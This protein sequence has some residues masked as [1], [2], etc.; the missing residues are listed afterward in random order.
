MSASSRAQGASRPVKS[1]RYLIKPLVWLVKDEASVKWHVASDDYFGTLA[2][3]ISL[4]KQQI[5]KDGQTAALKTTLN[6]LEKDLMYLQTRYQIN[7]KT[8]KR[9]KTPKG[10]L[11]SQ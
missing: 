4:L 9:I 1:R 7:P 10:R 6:N 11:K 5:K 2:T 3:I 8:K